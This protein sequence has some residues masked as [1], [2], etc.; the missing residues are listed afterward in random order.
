VGKVFDEA[1][2]LV[3]PFDG[4]GIRITVTTA[5][6]SARVVAAARTARG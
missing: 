4:D 1:G 2:V 6:D 5:A 3:R